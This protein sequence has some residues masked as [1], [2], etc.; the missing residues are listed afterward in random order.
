M[1]YLISA[2]LVL[3]TVSCNK[4][5]EIK[6]FSLNEFS[7]QCIEYKEFLKEECGGRHPAYNPSYAAVSAAVAGSSAARRRREREKKRKEMCADSTKNKVTKCIKY[8]VNYK[9]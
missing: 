2:L 7:V 4:S 5:S 1:K 3:T 9:E 8:E 6:I